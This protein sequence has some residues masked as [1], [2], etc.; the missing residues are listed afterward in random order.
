MTSTCGWRARTARSSPARA[1]VRLAPVGFCARGVQITARAPGVERAL[2]PVRRHPRARRRRPAAAA[3]PFSRSVLMCAR[4]H[5]SS[6][7]TASPRVR[8]AASS[9]SIASTAP[10]VT[11]T[12]NG[13]G[14][15]ARQSLGAPS[16][17]SS[18]VLGRRA[19][20]RRPRS[21]RRTSPTSGQQR[22]IGLP[23]ARSTSSRRADAPSRATSGSAGDRRPAAAVRLGHAGGHQ[24]PVRRRHRVAVHAQLAAPATRIGGS[25]SPARSAPCPRGRGRSPRSLPPSSR[26]STLIRAS[27]ALCPRTN[28]IAPRPCLASSATLS[29]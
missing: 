14:Q 2:E 21:R 20:Q 25:A 13:R 19:V 29:A 22:G 9:R 18:G 4:K 27:V 26:R 11:T 23:L 17:A 6:T 8:C 24:Q 7:A 5:G 10:W 12:S 1:A 15:I 3:N 16:A 28:V